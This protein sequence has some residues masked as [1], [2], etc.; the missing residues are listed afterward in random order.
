M[1]TIKTIDIGHTCSGGIING[2]NGLTNLR[3][4]AR[5]L[6]KTV[7]LDDLTADELTSLIDVLGAARLRSVSSVNELGRP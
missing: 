6:M 5:A 2:C 1:S 3:T 7:G 4:E